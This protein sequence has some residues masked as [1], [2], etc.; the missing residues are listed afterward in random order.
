DRAA[1]FGFHRMMDNAGAVAGALAAFFLTRVAGLPLRVVLGLAIVPGLVA[2][3]TLLFRVDE[4]HE[5]PPASARAAAEPKAALPAS[6]RPDLA[7]VGLFT[8]GASADS[9]LLLRMADLGLHEGWL[10]IVWLTL[11]ATK[12]ATNLPGGRLADRIGRARTLA[13]AWFVYAA[14]YAAFPL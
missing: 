7:V 8:L 2:M 4:R 12:S 14:V 13:I 1:A 10:P 5:L 6:H 11:N 9:F 3:A